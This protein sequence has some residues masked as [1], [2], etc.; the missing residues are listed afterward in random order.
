M[1]PGHD[2]RDTLDGRIVVRR[3]AFTAMD[4]EVQQHQQAEA[5]R[6]IPR[7]IVPVHVPP[8]K[9]GKKKT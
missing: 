2:G 9:K 7:P 5:D 4:R 1:M 6:Q 3:H 8:L